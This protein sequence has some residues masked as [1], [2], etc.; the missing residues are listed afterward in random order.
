MVK[1]TFRN[2]TVNRVKR[3][4]VQWNLRPRPK[5]DNAFVD[6][7]NAEKLV[8]YHEM[9]TPLSFKIIPSTHFRKERQQG[10]QPPEWRKS[11]PHW[12]G[13][14]ICISNRIYQRWT[15]DDIWLQKGRTI[16][17]GQNSTQTFCILLILHLFTDCTC[18]LPWVT[19]L[20]LWRHVYA[21]HIIPKNH[22]R[23]F[24]KSFSALSSNTS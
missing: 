19:W 6:A 13:V 1:S 14:L 4:P 22:R 18:P 8:M 17:G 20:V 21:K 2:T 15:T 7:W 23:H 12:E 11:T 9:R 3:K 24:K 5:K 10:T 16:I